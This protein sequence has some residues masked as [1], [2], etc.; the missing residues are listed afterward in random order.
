MSQEPLRY[1]RCAGAVHIVGHGMGGE[2]LL[3]GICT[4]DAAESES[5]ESLRWHEPKRQAVTC[6]QCAS[7]IAL[8]KSA[9]VSKTLREWPG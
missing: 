1:I 9:K 2:A 6:S 4:F 8:C 3:C 7:I 5:D